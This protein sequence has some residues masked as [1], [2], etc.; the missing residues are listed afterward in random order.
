MNDPAPISEKPVPAILAIIVTWNKKDDV[1]NLLESLET[2]DYPKPSLDIVVVDNASGDGTVEEIR[3]CY[4]SVKLI[5]NSENLGGT[6]GFNTGL[7][8]A[9]GTPAGTYDYLWL[10]DNDVLAHRRALAELVALLEAYPEAAIAGSTM[11]QLDYPWRI[12]EM[13]AWVNRMDGRLLLNRH[14]EEIPE[15]KDR[16]ARELLNSDVE[17]NITLFHSPPFIVVD[18]VAAASL[19]IRADVARNAGRWLDFF[20]H[21]DD[22][23]W[24]LRIARMGHQIV[25]SARSLI[26]HLSAA[27]KIPTWILY[28][29]NRNVLYLLKRHGKGG[30]ALRWAALKVLVKGARQVLIGKPEMKRLFLDALDDFRNGR[31]GKRE[32]PADI[33]GNYQDNQGLAEILTAPGVANL[34]IPWTVNIKATGLL[35]CLEKVIM[36]RPDVSVTFL[37]HDNNGPPDVSFRARNIRIE[38]SRLL[39]WG[40]F[41][42]LRKR[43]DYVFQSDYLPLAGL[44]LLGSPQIY[45]NDRT[46]SIRQSPGILAIVQ[47]LVDIFRRLPAV[48]FLKADRV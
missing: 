47:V 7:A 17:K 44:A 30:M 32:I 5:V 16:D 8:Y 20:I 39:R 13:G 2:I 31:M 38:D 29:D 43:Y 21:F 18:Y 27:A 3:R 9:Y 33:F 24:C 42:R 34:L 23:E 48:L 28:Y 11:M 36:K 26:W 4:P 35:S 1:L 46:F 37:L 25:V 40:T 10:L 14:L 19:L 15:W 22:V 41:F 6:G 12:N 45:I